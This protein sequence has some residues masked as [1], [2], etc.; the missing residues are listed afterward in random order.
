MR[1]A[2][3]GSVVEVRADEPVATEVARLF[4]PALFDPALFDPALFG[5]PEPHLLVT[6]SWAK[7]WTVTG[8][9]GSLGG[10][11][12]GHALELVLAQ[13]NAAAIAGCA[14]FAVHAGVVARE[15][16]ALALPGVSGAGKSTLVASLLQAGW[17]YVSDEALVAD[18]D[19]AALTAY[20]KP[21]TL[22]TW[23]LQRLGLDP[24]PAGRQERSLRV[25]ELGAHVAEG[26]LRL[27]RIV[28]P[29]RGPGPAAL[30]PLHRADAA[31]ELLTH[32]FNHWTDP[33]GSL[34]TAAALVRGSDTWT[35]T[36]DDPVEAAEILGRFS[37]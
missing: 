29:R 6:A 33:A 13:V 17:D 18:R 32:S 20:P 27:A 19:T 16:R 35:L 31:M 36:Y 9:Q 24:P 12:D 5:S 21:L 1:L 37:S 28:L 7:S 22:L 3:L 15:G 26:P 14:G 4:D 10:T 23:S 34:R 11:S 2:L 30:T 25:S 8:P